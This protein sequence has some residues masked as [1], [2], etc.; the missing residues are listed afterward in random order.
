MPKDKG[1]NDTHD[2][3]AGGDVGQVEAPSRN[4]RKRQ[5]QRRKQQ[6]VNVREKKLQQLRSQVVNQQQ[7]L[8]GEKSETLSDVN[9]NLMTD[10]HD[11][12]R[13]DQRDL[14][15]M[16][17]Q[18]SGDNNSSDSAT[19]LFNATNGMS[20]VNGI[21]TSFSAA[22]TMNGFADPLR[23]PVSSNPPNAGAV[24]S[25]RNLSPASVQTSA[26][27]TPILPST[28]EASLNPWPSR[29]SPTIS[30][31]TNHLTT[32]TLGP[33][34]P[35]AVDGTLPVQIR[36]PAAPIFSPSSPTDG[37][38]PRS[39]SPSPSPPS[40]SSSAPSSVLFEFP[41]RTQFCS[42]CGVA[43]AEEA[44]A[45]STSFRCCGECVAENID[46]PRLYCCID[47]LDMDWDERHRQD[48][49]R[50]NGWDWMEDAPDLD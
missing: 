49:E 35:Q 42:Y 2:Y 38:P 7:L 47:C 48:H 32:L 36:P 43:E 26:L 12:G 19:D 29:A 46:P 1:I 50:W 8:K 37:T 23:C 3:E 10:Q 40:T 17:Y 31:L 34:E 41:D 6:Q 44:G 21:S 20:D 16:S 45:S 11:R 5:R 22:P 9:G 24:S 28:N 4:Q 14:I 15:D 39:R 33:L 30:T 18:P 25:S 27:D 13:Q